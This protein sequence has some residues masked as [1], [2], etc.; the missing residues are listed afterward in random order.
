VTTIFRWVAAGILLAGG[1]P[2]LAQQ[3]ADKL[4]DDNQPFKGSLGAS[5]ELKSSKDFFEAKSVNVKKGRLCRIDLT[6]EDFD[7]YLRLFDGKKRLLAEDDDS[8]ETLNARLYVIASADAAWHLEA[9]SFLPGD[10]GAYELTVRSQASAGDNDGQL[11][12]RG[13]LTKHDKTDRRRPGCH[14]QVIHAVL[15]KG[16]RYTIDLESREF[17]AF[18]RV[19]DFRKKLLAEDDDSGKDF[20]AR[21]VFTPPE[22]ATYR[23]VVTTFAPATT[24]AFQF[25]FRSEPAKE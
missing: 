15:E 14:T 17:D 9:S 19:E 12:F 24:G 13:Q 11:V 21:V 2:L 7:P 1:V 16:T 25:K 23:F 18:L 8:G 10:Q 3:G 20:N 22:T 6:S 5:K 4:W